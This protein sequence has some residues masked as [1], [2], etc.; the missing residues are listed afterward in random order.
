MVNP[1]AGARARVS[2]NAQRRGARGRFAVVGGGPAGME[3]ARALAALGHR[4]ELFEATERAR[5]SV[6]HGAANSRK[7]R[8]R[9]ND[10]LF[11]QRAGAAARRRATRIRR[12]T[13]VAAL[14]G[15]DGDRARDRR[16]AAQRGA[17]PGSDLPARP[18]VRRRLAARLRRRRTRG[19]RRSRRNRR[20][21][22]ALLEFRRGERRRKHALSLRAGLGR[23][24]RRSAD[25]HRTQSRSRSCAAARRS[26]SASARRRAG[27]FC[28]RCAPPASK[29]WR[30]SPTTR[31]SRAAFACE[32]PTATRARSKR[33]RSSS[34]PAKSA[35]TR[36]LE[37]I[38]ALGV[39]FRVVGGAKDASEL[40]AVRAFEEGLR[41][42]HELARTYA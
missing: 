26:A 13:G 10:S 8:L 37:P 39:P 31:S 1:R 19:N 4:V 15:F 14:Q 9:R 6:S 7:A 42:A 36:L 30:T 41:A 40:N 24:A 34:P 25:R 16:R 35:T 3:S 38:R 33:I 18:F 27:P 12:V 23:A 21:R 29:R 20:R 5:R 11:H 32:P 17:L 28:A 22:R 2:R